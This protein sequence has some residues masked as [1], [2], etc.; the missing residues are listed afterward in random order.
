MKIPAKKHLG[1][2]FL[3]DARILDRLIQRIGA[4]ATDTFLEVGAGRGALSERLAPGVD[5]L[6]A[7]ELDPVCIPALQNS[8]SKFPSATVVPGDILDLDIPALVAPYLKAG[9]PLGWRGI[10]PITSPHRSLKDS[11]ASSFSFVTSRSWFN[12][13]SPSA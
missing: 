11:S 8:L 7:V 13:R 4:A 1:Q 3:R 5:R 12:W 9:Q 2:H 6:I 10:R